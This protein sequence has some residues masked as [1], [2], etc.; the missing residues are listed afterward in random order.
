MILMVNEIFRSIQGEGV[1]AGIPTTFIRLQGCNLF[2]G[3]CCSYCDTG[4]AQDAKDSKVRYFSVPEIVSEIVALDP[5]ANFHDWVCISGGEPLLQAGALEPLVRYLNQ[6]GWYTEI[7]TNGT[8][9][10]PKWW[11]LV[12]SWVPDVKCP[13]SGVHPSKALIDDWFT[14]R[15]Q[16]Q[17]KFVVSD[18]A[19]L[20]WAERIIR[21][22]ATASPQVLISPACTYFDKASAEVGVETFPTWDR[23][24]M[25]DCVDLCK[26]L[27]VR[28]SLQIHK[29][30]WGNKKG[31]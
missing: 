27:K 5:R 26:L 2:P 25:N 22:H 23:E 13:S 18:E 24:L 15:P 29:I 20:I 16:D 7:E 4:Y 14:T 30:V 12:T 3:G 8:L 6:A 19:D 11:T 21:D 10:K 17:I 31:V 1:Y 9:P 28:F